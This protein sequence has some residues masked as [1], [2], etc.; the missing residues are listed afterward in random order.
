MGL[1]LFHLML[2]S[3]LNIEDYNIDKDDAENHYDKD[4]TNVCADVYVY[5]D[6]LGFWLES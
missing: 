4:I 5:Q 3:C 1:I 2:F 6:L